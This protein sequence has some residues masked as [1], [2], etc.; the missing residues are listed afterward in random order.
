MNFQNKHS[1]LDLHRTISRGLFLIRIDII[2]VIV[3][4]YFI[5]PIDYFSLPVVKDTALML[6][7]NF[8]TVYRT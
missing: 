8:D 4:Q 5:H 3:N 1:W 2:L 6:A 7:R